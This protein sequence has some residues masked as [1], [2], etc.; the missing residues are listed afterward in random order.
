MNE[1]FIHSFVHGWDLARANFTWCL[2]FGSCH[3]RQ[4][5]KCRGSQSPY[6]ILALAQCPTVVT[7]QHGPQR[8]RR[9]CFFPFGAS[10][11]LLFSTSILDLFVLHSIL[12]LLLFSFPQCSF[13]SPVRGLL[14]RVLFDTSLFLSAS[15]GLGNFNL[16]AGRH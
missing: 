9:K 1:L 3:A 10:P 7:C 6:Q 16:D 2:R 5:A 4:N 14:G 15:G 12:L 13:F 8:P 11:Y